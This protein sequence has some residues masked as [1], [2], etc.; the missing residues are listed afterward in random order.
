[1]YILLTFLYVFTTRKKLD[2]DCDL[3]KLG[4]MLGDI[5]RTWY[6]DK[7]WDVKSQENSKN[8]AYTNLS[9]GLHMDLLHYENPPRYQL[10][11]YLY[12]HPRLTGGQSYFVDS[13]K[14]AEII[15]RTE[16]EVYETLC[17]TPVAF[18]YRNGGHWRHYERPTFE[19]QQQDQYDKSGKID[20]N[21]NNSNSNNNSH[22]FF[23][24]A[25]NYSPPF[26]AP[27]VLDQIGGAHG[28]EKLH[29]ALKTFANLAAQ[30]ELT[31]RIDM[32]P[33]DC[34]A[35]DNRRVLHARTAFDLQQHHPNG[36]NH[37]DGGN[38]DSAANN[39]EAMPVR[40]LKGAYVEADS[41]AD[42]YRVLSEA[43]DRKQ[44]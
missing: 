42:T 24:N 12:S 18:E 17:E 23:L 39:D 26:Q 27:Q 37:Y 1:M 14:I 31:Y 44:E 11:H 33:G 16:P 43:L 19:R 2:A 25:V 36:N 29:H 6:G 40:W 15:R 3:V 20:I 28:M 30:P 10:L 21:K 35:F 34:V 8:V 5:R 9:L 7:V 32:K 38:N 13:F 4:G 41:V 22:K